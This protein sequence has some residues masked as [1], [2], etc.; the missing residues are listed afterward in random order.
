MKK[1][2]IIIQ[3]S[4]LLIAQIIIA[5]IKCD[6]RWYLYKYSKLY[7]S[8]KF[9]VKNREDLIKDPK[10]YNCIQKLI[11]D[12]QFTYAKLKNCGENIISEDE[13]NM[14]KIELAK[15]PENHQ[16]ICLPGYKTLD[17]SYIACN[18]QEK[19]KII[20]VCL[21][22]IGLGFG[23][24]YLQNYLFFFAKFLST[25]LFC[26]MIFVIFL[27]GAL[28]D[29]NVSNETKERS[30][31]IVTWILP[32][33]CAIYFADIITFLFDLRTDSNGQALSG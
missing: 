28:S 4:L 24:F 3:N 20:A 17:S 22:I 13:F 9:D 5:L 31:K 11:F 7:N 12:K 29:S 21:E 27:V 26:Y 10:A 6:D 18:Y 15:N 2:N 33:Y 30:Q 32:V 1:N 16:N 25:Y 14:K 8:Y 19:K 23:H